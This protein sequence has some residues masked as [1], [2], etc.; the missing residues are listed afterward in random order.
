MS[1]CSGPHGLLT[2]EPGFPVILRL[3][4]SGPVVGV[5]Y[6]WAE[7]PAN[8]VTGAPAY[9]ALEC[10]VVISH[11]E[12]DTKLVHVFPKGIPPYPGNHQNSNSTELVAKRI[13]GFKGN[14]AC[15]ANDEGWCSPAGGGRESWLTAAKCYL[16][17]I[18]GEDVVLTFDA[19]DGK[20]FEEIAPPHG[21]GSAFEV[22]RGDE[23][24]GQILMNKG[25]D[26][27]NP[28][29]LYQ[30]FKEGEGL[31]PGVGQSVSEGEE[32]PPKGRWLKATCKVTT[33]V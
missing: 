23:L 7:V 6:A 16:K 18:A 17:R 3:G 8:G 10:W 19:V 29:E 26:T 1:D 14:E 30:F 13:V 20:G 4:D 12:G 9:P 28:F 32:C 2:F 11:V 33:G 27:A 24:I 15:L 31:G 21:F 25:A 22:R 5:A